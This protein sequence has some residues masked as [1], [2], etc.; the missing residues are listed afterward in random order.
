MCHSALRV[1]PLR[2][3]SVLHHT[4][5]RTLLE[6]TD[7]CRRLGRNPPGPPLDHREV[8]YWTTCNACTRLEAAAGG[9]GGSAEVQPLDTLHGYPF[10]AWISSERLRDVCS[11][12]TNLTRAADVGGG[13]ALLQ[14]VP[15]AH[16]QCEQA[17]RAV[18]PPAAGGPSAL[19][20]QPGGGSVHDGRPGGPPGDTQPQTGAA[21]PQSGLEFRLCDGDRSFGR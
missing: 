20:R 6:V 4:Q 17:L 1:R 7:A 9:A 2:A 10:P 12:S 18:R 5:V 21:C 8:W 3:G 14:Q 19:L 11:E 13:S 15:G 16:L